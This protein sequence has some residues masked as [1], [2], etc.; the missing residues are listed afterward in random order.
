MKTILVVE[1]NAID[2]ALIRRAFDAVPSCRAIVCRNLG[3]ARAYLLGAGIY[4]DRV[5]YPFP[6]A[7]ICDFRL[8]GESGNE[9]LIWL[10]SDPRSESLPV[11]ILSGSVAPKDL[12]EAK[13]SG[14]VDVLL[15]P[16]RFDDLKTL[17]AD[18]AQKH[19][20]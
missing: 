8:G 3:E 18:V 4:E 11:V 13:K 20:C 19:C 7:V 5:E 15:K 9:F 2:A 14:A 6:N 12:I 16:F 10:K 17:V 1:D